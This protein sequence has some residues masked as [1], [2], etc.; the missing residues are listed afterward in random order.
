M[1]HDERVGRAGS[2]GYKRVIDRLGLVAH[3]QLEQIAVVGSQWC[4]GRWQRRAMVDQFEAV[5]EAVGAILNTVLLQLFA[6]HVAVKL[7]Q[8]VDQ[9]RNLAKSVT[10]E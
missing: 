3:R 6:Y 5:E 2:H 1:Q 8:D 4:R 10:V 7:G 9:P